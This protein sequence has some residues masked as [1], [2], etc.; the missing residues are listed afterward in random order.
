MTYFLYYV[1]ILPTKEKEFYMAKNNYKL[2]EI[3]E[4]IADYSKNNAFPPS[5]REIQNQFG[6]RSTS[7]VSYYLRKLEAN[8]DLINKGRKNRALSISDRYLNANP[9]YKPKFLNTDF[10]VVPLV[11]NVTAGQP[12]LAEENY[13]DSFYIPTNMFRGDNLFMLKVIGE[14]MIDAGIYDG[15]KIIVRQQNTA[16]N[17]EIV[18]ALIEN[19]ATVKTYYKE[20]GRVRLQPQN[21]NMSAMYFD[22]IA[23]LGKVIGLIRQF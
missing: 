12:I 14:S 4:F 3:L 13:E 2:K 6:F 20:D 5:I 19:S 10:S 1:I 22:N 11:G 21:P 17:G 8:G 16:E 23:I 15:D 9:K 18:V 7:T